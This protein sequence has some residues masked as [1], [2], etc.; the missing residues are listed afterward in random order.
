MGTVS[1]N[2]PSDGETIDAADVT[3]PVNTIV[4][5]ING[6]L[7]NA[8][9]ASDAAISGSKLADTSITNAKLA[10]S[11]G[12]P[13]GAWEDWT[14]TLVNISGGTQNFAKYKRIGNTVHYKFSYTLAGAGVAGDATF[15]L[16]VTAVAATDV[17]QQIGS[18]MYVDTGTAGHPGVIVQSSTTTGR[19]RSFRVDATYA[20]HAAIGASAPFTWA[21]TDI[22]YAYGTYEAA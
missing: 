16:P 22:I 12:E 6:N 8:N 20:T 14:P 18:A 21:N 15:S 10:T 7:D 9:I 11:T 13:G 5:E 4:N 1:V 17:N 19:F 2:T 3:T